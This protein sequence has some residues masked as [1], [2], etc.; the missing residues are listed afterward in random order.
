ML[1]EGEGGGGDAPAKP[2][3]LSEAAVSDVLNAAHL[4]EASK[5]RIREQQWLSEYDLK[6]AVTAEINYIKA[7]TG[8]G[9]VPAGSGGEAPVQEAS[10]EEVNKRK[11]AVNAKFLGKPSRMKAAA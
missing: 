9:K 7:I 4:P 10:L 2:A 6:T 8:S 5:A 3:P 11:D 1:K